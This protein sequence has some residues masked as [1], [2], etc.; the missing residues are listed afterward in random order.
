MIN[1][2]ILALERKILNYPENSLLIPELL[3]FRR[4]GK[5]MEAS[6]G[7]HDDTVMSLAFAL[8]GCPLAKQDENPFADLDFSNLLV[9]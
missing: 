7:C 8:A 1:R 9:D 3:N 4:V 5:S 2:I 6:S